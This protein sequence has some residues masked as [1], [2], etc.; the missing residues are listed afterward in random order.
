[1]EVRLQPRGQGFGLQIGMV[2]VQFMGP[3]GWN[4][5]HSNPPINHIAELHHSAASAYGSTP[6]NNIAQVICRATFAHSR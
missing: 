3:P 4:A 5:T 2:P 1:M 6:M